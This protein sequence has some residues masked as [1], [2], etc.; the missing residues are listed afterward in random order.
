MDTIEGTPFHRADVEAAFTSAAGKP[1]AVIVTLAAVR[2]SD[3][4]F[5]KPI[6]PP[7]FMHDSVRN[8]LAVMEQHGVKKLVIVSALGTGDSISRLPWA[9]KLLFRHS[10]MRYQYE[11]HDAV[12]VEV[13]A[14]RKIDWTLVRPPMFKDGEAKAV[15]EFGEV[16]KGLG[17]FDSVTRASVA[18]FLVTAVENRTWERKA[19]VIAN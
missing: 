13:R 9:F 8:A 7:M 19:V 2:A 6:G 18:E 17:M 1:D 3:S 16:G 15:R 5:A 14:A 4:P 11:D 10:N 12:D